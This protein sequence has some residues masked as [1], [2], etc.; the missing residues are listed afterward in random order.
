MA[1]EIIQMNGTSEKPG[2]TNASVTTTNQTLEVRDQ[3][4]LEVYPGTYIGRRDA[5]PNGE[6]TQTGQILA[7]GVEKAFSGF[8]QIGTDILD[9]LSDGGSSK[10]WHLIYSFAERY[11]AKAC[12]WVQ[13]QE[14]T[15]Q[16]FIYSVRRDGGR[17][18]FDYDLDHLR[19]IYEGFKTGYR[20]RLL[21][22]ETRLKRR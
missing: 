11:G 21:Y 7:G 4:R 18:V 15:Y 3:T 8:E 12:E 17:C 10:D 13:D 14:E 6:A 5:L 1:K 2:S 22:T 16:S 20:A 9:L 19:G